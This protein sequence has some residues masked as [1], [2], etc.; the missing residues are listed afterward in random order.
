MADE[1]FE[2]ESFEEEEEE[3]QQEEQIET[4]QEVTDED[5]PEGAQ[6]QQIRLNVEDVTPEYANFCTLT[7]RQGEVFMSYGKAFAPGNELKV[8]NQIVMSMRNMQQLHQAIGRL[9]EQQDQLPE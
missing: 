7:V 8:D 5:L 1:G 9:L 4:P 6:G 2:Q 3:E